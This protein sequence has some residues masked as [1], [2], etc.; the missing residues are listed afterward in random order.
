MAGNGCSVLVEQLEGPVVVHHVD[1]SG[2]R[3]QHHAALVLLRSTVGGLGRVLC[4]AQLLRNVVLVAPNLADSIFWL[5]PA[6]GRVKAWVVYRIAGRPRV[7]ELLPGSVVVKHVDEPTCV[8]GHR[9]S[10]VEKLLCA[11]EALFCGCWTAE[12]LAYRGVSI[13][14][15][16]KAVLRRDAARA[17]A[18]ARLGWRRH[19]RATSRRRAWPRRIRLRRGRRRIRMRRGWRWIRMRRGWRWLW[20]GAVDQQL[21]PRID[22]IRVGNSIALG[23]GPHVHAVARSDT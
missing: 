6:R 1:A 18:V 4:P 22:P 10:I 17:A 14:H 15:R 3:P 16:A 8:V 13:P 12:L 11:G 19:V 2:R 9:E 7:L 23:N 21:L 20:R 5:A